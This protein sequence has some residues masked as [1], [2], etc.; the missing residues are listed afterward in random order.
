M[1]PDRWREIDALLQSA[2]QRPTE[3]RRT[4]LAEACKGDP[5]LLREVES[6]IRHHD[7]AGATL[8][9]LPADVASKWQDTGRSLSRREDA[10][11]TTRQRGCWAQAGWARSTLRW[12]PC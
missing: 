7:L 9:T 5:E 6:L 4:F 11:L 10:F 3:E 12:T 1:K 2:L 8:E